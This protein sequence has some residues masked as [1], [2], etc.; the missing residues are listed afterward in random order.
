MSTDE[1]KI[2]SMYMRNLFVDG[3]LHETCD[4]FPK[5]KNEGMKSISPHRLM[6]KSFGMLFF[7]LSPF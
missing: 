4:A 1:V 7:D 6:T 5:Q 2:L 3:I